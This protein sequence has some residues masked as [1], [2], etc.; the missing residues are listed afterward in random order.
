[1]LEKSSVNKASLH[2]TEPINIHDFQST[3]SHLR[4][5]DQCLGVK[6]ATQKPSKATFC[7]LNMAAHPIGIWLR[8]DSC[9]DD[10][11]VQLE[12][13]LC[14][15]TLGELPQ[16][17]KQRRNIQNCQLGRCLALIWENPY[18]IPSD[19]VR[20]KDYLKLSNEKL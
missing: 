20:S 12:Q 1:M 17:V 5:T 7:A 9:N 4:S 13:F 2:L 10:F 16:A 6:I 8:Q 18:V 19:A 14:D 3:C 15:N 11:Q